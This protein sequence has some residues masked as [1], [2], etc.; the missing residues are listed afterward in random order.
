MIYTKTLQQI[1]PYITLIFST[2]CWLFNTS[3]TAIYIYFKKD[4]AKSGNIK[5]GSRNIWCES[6]DREKIYVVADVTQK[7]E[8]RILFRWIVQYFLKKN[9]IVEAKT[10]RFW[11][12]IIQS[13]EHVSTELTTSLGNI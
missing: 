2:P 12:N 13:A 6:F 5:H 8:V 9:L 4:V 11:T 10:L 3:D 1:L 7:K